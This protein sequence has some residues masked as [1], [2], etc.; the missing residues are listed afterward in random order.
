MNNQT[1]TKK[2][3]SPNEF[4]NQALGRRVSVKLTNNLEYRGMY[5]YQLTIKNN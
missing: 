2:L 3:P 1:Q 4:L 5:T